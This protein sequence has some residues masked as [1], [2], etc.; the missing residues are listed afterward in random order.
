MHLDIVWRNF[1]KNGIGTTNPEKISDIVI[2]TPTTPFSFNVWVVIIG[3]NETIAVI[4]SVPA[5]IVSKNKMKCGNDAGSDILYGDGS[6]IR[7]TRNGTDLKRTFDNLSP[8][9]LKYHIKYK[10]FGLI[11]S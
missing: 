8:I 10:F 3:Y 5:I 7:K 4:S 11:N 2:I 6:S 9:I 1:G